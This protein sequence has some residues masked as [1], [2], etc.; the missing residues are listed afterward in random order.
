LEASESGYDSLIAKVQELTNETL[1]GKTAY[2]AWQETVREFIRSAIEQGNLMSANTSGAIQAFQTTLMGTTKF[3][4]DTSAT[5]ETINLLKMAYDVHYGDMQNS[6]EQAIQAHED[7][8]NG[9]Y[10]SAVEVVAALNNQWI[11]QDRWEKKVE[12]SEAIVYDYNLAIINLK[13]DYEA[14]GK[15][16]SDTTD[17]IN[18]YIESARQ[19]GEFGMSR[20]STGRSAGSVVYNTNQND[21][22]NYGGTISFDTG[23]SM[24]MSKGFAAKVK[25]AQDAG[26]M[27]DGGLITRPT[28]AMIGE[29]GPELVI[30][31]SE[32]KSGGFGGGTN[33][34]IGQ[35]SISGVSGNASDFAYAFAEELRRELSTQ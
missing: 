18:D 27:A 11:A 10:D 9:V 26:L 7:E 5:E 2:E 21:D 29:G 12:E 31:L 23:G 24:S 22:S 15:S 8:K 30:P 4:D 17:D 14:L 3:G 1:V 13:E 25:E 20:Y 32:L 35:I 16:I 28:L 19:A 33:V 34:S 6:V